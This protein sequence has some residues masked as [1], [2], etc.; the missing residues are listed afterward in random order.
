MPRFLFRRKADATIILFTL[1]HRNEVVNFCDIFVWYFQKF[2]LNMNDGS[3]IHSS[4]QVNVVRMLIICFLRNDILVVLITLVDNN[5]HCQT[6]VG[7]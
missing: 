3:F 4:V 5:W 1:F 6:V 7:F 2:L